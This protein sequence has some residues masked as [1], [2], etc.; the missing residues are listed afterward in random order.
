LQNDDAIVYVWYITGYASLQPSLRISL[1]IDCLWAQYSGDK[2]NAMQTIRE[3]QTSAQKSVD[4]HP[5]HHPKK[6]N[7]F[8]EDPDSESESESEADDEGEDGASD[9][10]EYR[11]NDDDYADEDGDEG[12]GDCDGDGD[13]H[14][15]SD[16][17]YDFRGDDEDDEDGHD[18]TKGA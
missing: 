16:S 2:T 5:P 14:M 1:F 8:G 4:S 17:E 18:D 15:Q 6:M 3:A 12:D 9:D 10:G 7:I 13:I 11:E